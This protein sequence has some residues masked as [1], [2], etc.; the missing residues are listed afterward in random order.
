MP[1][2]STAPAALRDQEL[3]TRYCVYSSALLCIMVLVTIV[4]VNSAT[5]DPGSPP[6]TGKAQAFMLSGV[7]Q[8]VDFVVGT[9]DELWDEDALEDPDRTWIT[10]FEQ[11]LATALNSEDRGL[12]CLGTATD[13]QCD[14][15]HVNQCAKWRTPLRVHADTQIAVG[16]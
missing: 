10:N 5:A 14:P 8:R 15:E 7:V 6:V 4:S 16:T 13:P 9:D 1:A 2:T 11:S 12:P 3:T